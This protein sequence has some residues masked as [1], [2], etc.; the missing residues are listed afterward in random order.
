MGSLCINEVLRDDELRSIL[1]R[2]EDDKDK[3]RFGLVCKRWLH[4][5]ST[6]RKKLSVRA[7][8]HMLRKIAARFS[9]LVELDLSQSVSRS[10]YPGVTDSDLAVITDG[11]KSLKLLNLQN[12]KGITDAGIAS[13]G[14]GLCSLQSLDLSYCRK[15]TDK[16]LSAVAE[17]CQDLRSLHLAG[18]K[19][20]TDGTLQAL[21]KNCHNLEE[22]GLQGCTSISDSGVIDLVNG[23]Q[24]IKF[25]DLN[26]CS[27]IGDIG[28]SSV[29]KSCSSSLKTLKLL[30]CYKV[31]DKSIL[32]L[33]KFCKNLE[34]LIIGG[35]R[36]ISDESIKHLAASC[37][38]SL[39]NLRMDWCLN[40]SDSSLSFIL[41]QCRNLEALD[42]GCCEEVTDAAFQD[43]GE[44][45]LS[46]KV[47]KVNCP[48]VT[49][50][51]IGNVLEKCASLEYI[52][53]R[54]CPHVTQA[55]C[56][57]AGLQFPQCCKVNFA[58][59][60]FEPDVLL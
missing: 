2:L 27:N 1:S 17:G 10:F 11:F 37:K 15:L 9:R 25:L 46:L 28:I 19:S 38:S 44:V 4:L 8:P 48:K 22:L 16:G 32:S 18:C 39:K 23:C 45:E 26:K 57:E 12:C 30:D 43:L 49:V 5:Q 55:S 56:E 14:S 21:S 59:C 42:I 53:V 58:G 60:L 13:I 36:D 6:E 52:D 35:C 50:V 20:V 34:T 40:I 7:G 47:L 31:G 29:S 24:N 41:S 51:G 33:A 54:S 3:E